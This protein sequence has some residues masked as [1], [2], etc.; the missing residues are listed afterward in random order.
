MNYIEKMRSLVNTFADK[1]HFIVNKISSLK[2]NKVEFSIRANQNFVSDMKSVLPNAPYSFRYG[3]AEYKNFDELYQRVQKMDTFNINDYVKNPDSNR[4][5]ICINLPESEEHLQYLHALSEKNDY[6]FLNPQFMARNPMQGGYHA[7]TTVHVV[8]RNTYLVNVYIRKLRHERDSIILDR[9]KQELSERVEN[10]ESLL[11][12]IGGYRSDNHKVHNRTKV[13]NYINVLKNVI[14]NCTIDAII[15]NDMN[16]FS[17]MFGSLTIS[18]NLP[19]HLYFK[20]ESDLLP[21]IFKKDDPNIYFSQT[22][23]FRPMEK[24]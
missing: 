22:V 10:I 23:I 16:Y 20:E 7:R 24:Q 19:I 4:H 13:E 5:K 15:Q 21:F 6:K 18:S 12:F 11:S 3:P 9:I 2:K 8:F 14:D 1:D 17:N